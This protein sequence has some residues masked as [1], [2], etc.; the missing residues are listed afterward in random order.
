[1][2]DSD[3]LDSWKD[4]A[5]YL[6]KDIRT[7]QRW[8]SEY[9]LPVHR[10]I[11]S[12]RSRVFAFRSEIDMWLKSAKWPAAEGEREGQKP[13]AEQCKGGVGRIGMVAALPV[14]ALAIFLGL[15]G[16]KRLEIAAVDTAGSKIRLL[17]GKQKT[18]GEWDAGC[19]LDKDFYWD[20]KTK[21]MPASEADPGFVMVEG[22]DFRAYRGREYLVL[23]PNMG[24]DDNTLVCLSD[25][26]KKRWLFEPKVEELGRERRNPAG[27]ETLVRIFGFRVSDL[28]GDG[29]EEVVVLSYLQD[30]SRARIDILSERGE[31]EGGFLNPGMLKDFALADV[32][33]D[34]AVEILA[35][36]YC[37]PEG[38]PALA[39]IDPLKMGGNGFAERSAAEGLKNPDDREEG[40]ASWAAEISRTDHYVLFPNNDIE[41]ALNGKNVLMRVEAMAGEANG[42]VEVRNLLRFRLVLGQGLIDVRE[43]TRFRM[44]FVETAGGAAGPGPSLDAYLAAIKQAGIRYLN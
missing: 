17:D 19:L 12:S 13:E 32:D 22:A 20:L 30:E 43:T 14:L 23:I 25:R 28:D 31:R 18:A 33:G 27:S 40:R 7:C 16:A 4:V 24:K 10:Y 39:V 36:G 26:G 44:E 3:R 2:S 41:T 8:H 5:D 37:E 29:R 15:G 35:A 38:A 34:L 1:M 11:Q 9:G 6:R 21:R 42:T